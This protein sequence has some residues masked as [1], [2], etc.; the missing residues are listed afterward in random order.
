MIDKPKIIIHLIATN[1]FGG[2]EKQIIEHLKRL[3][4][5]EFEGRLVSY[6]EYGEPNR[7]LKKAKDEGIRNYGISMHGPL[8]FRA[9]LKLNKLISK[10]KIDLLF[11]HGYKA[12]VMGWW[13]AK[14]AE[15]PVIAFSRGYTSEN[16]KIAFYNW[17]ERR[18]LRGMD[19]IIAVSDGQRKRLESYGIQ[20]RKTWVVHNAISV[21]SI[22]R[23]PDL[24]KRQSVLKK[25]NISINSKL[26]VT[27]GRFS[28]EKGH[29]YLVEAISKLKN[30]K[31]EV[32]FVFCGD[33]MCKNDIVAQSQNLGVFNQCRFPGFREDLDEIFEVM[34]LMVLP[35][36][37][38][39][40]PNVI[41]EAFASAKPVV[42]TE[43]GGVP[44]IIENGK[45]GLLVPVRSPELLAR[46]IS[47]CFSNPDLM[48]QMGQAGHHKVK[49]EFNFEKQNKK[50]ENINKEV[51]HIY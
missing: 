30:I 8:D 47:K 35:S 22:Q 50:L 2:P 34:D 49:S 11:V 18:F 4:K 27:A 39:G 21:N 1:F 5:D 38:E 48:K 17:L 23:D 32:C 42:A 9:Q 33:G 15:I 12:C 24:D 36:L 3:N 44:E 26:V 31:D 16:L 51:L 37:A 7:L 41:L 14:L 25:L 43:V 6:L 19:G 45:N 10:E 20:S 46:A 28:P 29:R 40:L 13:S